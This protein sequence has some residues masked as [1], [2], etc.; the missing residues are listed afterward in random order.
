MH[1]K[2]KQTSAKKCRYRNRI[3][4]RHQLRRKIDYRFSSNDL[5]YY[6]A[7]WG[8]GLCIYLRQR[9]DEVPGHSFEQKYLIT[10][11]YIQISEL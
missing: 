4:V 5:G 9:D 8:L 2:N 1:W 10:K 11:Y 6:H 3:K 7:S